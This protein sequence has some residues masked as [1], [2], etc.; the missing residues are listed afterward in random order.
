MFRWLGLFQLS[1]KGVQLRVRGAVHSDAL[2]R[3]L[4]IDSVD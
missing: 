1:G 3:D 2:V 4:E